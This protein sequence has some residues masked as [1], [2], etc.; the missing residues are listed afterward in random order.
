MLTKNE[1]K[2]SNDS[3][4]D[5][6]QV[7]TD[8]LSA[9]TI[10]VT[11]RHE[12]IGKDVKLHS[13]QICATVQAGKLPDDDSKRAPVDIV[14]AL[15]VSGSMSGDKLTLCKKTLE[16]LLRNLLPHDRF[17]LVSFADEAVLEIPTRKLT[18]DAKKAAIE[19][20]RNI[21]TRGCTNIS[22]AIGLAAQEMGCVE[23][24]NIVRSIFLLTDGLANRGVSHASGIVDI[25]KGC[26]VNTKDDG[27]APITIHCFGYGTD[28]DD[29]LLTDVSEATPGGSYY[30]VE[31][32]S[33]V[34]S[35]F[36]DALGGILSVVAQN[37]SINIY[38]PPEAAALGVEIIS[39]HH[40]NKIKRDNGSIS[41]TL[42]DLYAEESRDVLFEIK[43]ANPPSPLVDPL[44]HVSVVLSYLDTIKKQLI[45]TD[46]VTCK[47]AR[48]SGAEVS[49]ANQHVAVQWLRI[50]AAKEMEHVDLLATRGDLKGARERINQFKDILQEERELQSDPLVVQIS[51][52]LDSV[53]GGITDRRQYTTFGAKRIQMKRQAHTTQRC[54]ETSFTSD[55]FYRGSN[56]AK[57][58]KKFENAD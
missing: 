11:P 9:L 7:D 20:I 48:P 4:M 13:T 28:H 37:V 54:A 8:H 52:D 42:G 25:A 1:T 46:P 26:L 47:I 27:T 38:I 5:C 57:M 29:K 44:S 56:K 34:A 41:V 30:F 36:G 19:K 53:M 22:A 43:L 18:E 10:S 35:A 16:L 12:I 32:D 58:A 21:R 2:D 49:E 55:N 6:M 3:F 14:I 40:E 24:P 39:V 50:N 33:N 51:N 23:N 31:N 17:G 45:T 15:D